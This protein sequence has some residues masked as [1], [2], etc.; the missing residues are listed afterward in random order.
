MGKNKEIFNIKLWGI[1]KDVK[2]ALKES[3]NSKIYKITV[4]LDSQMALKQ[5][6]NV[7]I[8]AGQELKIYTF[9]LAKQFY[10]WGGEVLVRLVPSNKRIERNDRAHN[11][12]KDTPTNGRSEMVQ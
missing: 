12:V 8:N 3:T 11:T 9:R 4:F 6:Y 5:L 2:R 10:N 7:K 1:L